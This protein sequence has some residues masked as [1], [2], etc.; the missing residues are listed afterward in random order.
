MDDVHGA[1]GTPGIVEHPLLVRIDVARHAGL[2]VQLVD[3]V[4]DDGARVIAVQLNAALAYLLELVEVEDIEGLE[5][6]LKEVDNRGEHAEQDGE[7]LEPAAHVARAAGAG[8]L[9]G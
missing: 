6:L 8:R 9:L 4:L 1:H 2:A 3:D 5:V 7:E